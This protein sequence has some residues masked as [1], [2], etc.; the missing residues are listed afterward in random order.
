M[1]MHTALARGLLDGM[2]SPAWPHV[3]ARAYPRG[4]SAVIALFSPLGLAKASLVAAGLSYVVFH[5]G[6]SRLVPWQLALVAVFL[7]R[8]PQTFFDWGGNPTALAHGLGFAAAGAARDGRSFLA[9]LLLAGSAA[10][11]PMGACAGAIA[12]VVLC[13][14]EKGALLACGGALAG[15][16]AVLVVLLLFGPKLSPAE[17]AWIR[18]YAR[19]KEAIPLRST[20]AVVGDPVAVLSGVCALLLVWKRRFRAVTAAALGLAGC[21]ALFHVLPFAGLYPIRFAPLVLLCL[22][23]LWS[24]LPKPAL[25]AALAVAVPF[26]VHWYQRAAP[27]ATGDDLRAI[28]CV[29][30]TVPAGAIIDGAYGD[31]TQ[32]IPAL[33]GHPVTHPHVHVSFFDEAALGLAQMPPPSFRF[34]G[35]RLR[36]PSP[37]A[38]LPS[39][40]E[41]LCDGHLARLAP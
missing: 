32:W 8:T 15:L 24:A 5:L 26:H 19:T 11:H 30:R 17:T 35:E 20:L 1:A 27:I 36:Y 12:V 34:V 28:A 23:P 29:A 41:P 25:W 22:V 13:P 33:T 16:A 7:S 18:E 40:A 31:A 38:P 39:G 14:H 21:A 9:A 2:L 10:V 4:L 37:R 3:A 6:L